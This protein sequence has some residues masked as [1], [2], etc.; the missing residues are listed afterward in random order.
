MREHLERKVFACTAS[1]PE[2]CPYAV[3]VAFDARCKP[4]E[5]EWQ[6]VPTFLLMKRYVVT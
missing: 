3:V 5:L 2:H 1:L 4:P 6:A